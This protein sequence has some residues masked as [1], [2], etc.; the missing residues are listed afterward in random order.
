MRADKDLIKGAVVLAVAMVGTL[1]DGAGNALIGMAITI[2][3]ISSFSVDSPLVCLTQTRLCKKALA[4]WTQ[5]AII[6]KKDLLIK[7][8]P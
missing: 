4:K 6:W 3:S 2:H 7:V 5:H 8:K 1:R